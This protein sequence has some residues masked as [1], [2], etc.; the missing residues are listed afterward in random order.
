MIFTTLQQWF[1]LMFSTWISMTVCLLSACLRLC[2]LCLCWWGWLGEKEIP[3]IASCRMRSTGPTIVGQD[4]QTRSRGWRKIRGKWMPSGGG[5]S[6]ERCWRK[7][8][9]FLKAA[10]FYQV[11]L[12]TNDW[13]G[14][15]GARSYVYLGCKRQKRGTSSK[16]LL[17]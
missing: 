4:S 3:F 10:S 14:Q 16:L 13:L 6:K 17:N 8:Y 1:S 2:F 5:A 9:V 15:R 11:S 12:N 7:G